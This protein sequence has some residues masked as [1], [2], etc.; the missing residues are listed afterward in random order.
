MGRHCCVTYCTNNSAKTTG[1]SYYQIP[2]NPEK[3][4]K[5]CKAINR[6][7]T[8]ADGRVIPGKLWVPKSDYHY[9]CSQ[10]FISGR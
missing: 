1:I 10:H 7:A 5:W 3:R 9:V 8:T 6:V 2:T 4:L